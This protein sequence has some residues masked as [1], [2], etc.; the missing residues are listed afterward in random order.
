MSIGSCASPHLTSRPKLASTNAIQSDP[1]SRYR[2]L[3][4]RQ[5]SEV[6]ERPTPVICYV[7]LSKY[8]Q[9]SFREESTQ[10][11]DDLQARVWVRMFWLG[12]SKSELRSFIPR[13]LSSFPFL[14]PSSPSFVCSPVLANS[15]RWSDCL[16]MA[17]DFVVSFSPPFHFHICQYYVI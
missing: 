14:P 16:I 3:V 7:G 11:S 10:V 5:L 15:P 13:R 8:Y 9:A 1:Y 4:G 12:E 6:R 17:S 2:P